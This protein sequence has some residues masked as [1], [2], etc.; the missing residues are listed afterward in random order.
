MSPCTSE[1]ASPALLPRRAELPAACLST[2]A[3]IS[4]RASRVAEMEAL[5]CWGS[6]PA[7]ASRRSAWC[8]ACSFRTAALALR[9]FLSFRSLR[10]GLA[11]AQQ[12]AVGGFGLRRDC[13]QS[14]HQRGVPVHSCCWWLAWKLRTCQTG[15]QSGEAG[16]EGEMVWSL[17]WDKLQVS[18]RLL[19]ACRCHGVLRQD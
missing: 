11:P 17:P 8:W 1:A 19:L 7:S 9:R 3:V 18:R 15:Q 4:S 6:A 10:L 5:R 16:L 2:R 14:H 12:Q 13:L